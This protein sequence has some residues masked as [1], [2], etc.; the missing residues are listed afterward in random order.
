MALYQLVDESPDF[1]AIDNTVIE[2]MEF[3]SKQ[4]TILFIVKL[5]FSFTASV[6]GY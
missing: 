1:D 2:N 3:E 4:V 6:F 5:N